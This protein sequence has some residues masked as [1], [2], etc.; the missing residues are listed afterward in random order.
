M[1]WKSAGEAW[2]FRAAEWAY[3]FE[4]Y[5][6][7]ANVAVLDQCGVTAGTS[8]LDIGCGSGYALR[9]AADRGASVSG[10]DASESLLRIAAART[11]YAD[12]RLGD[13]DA[14]PWDDN[15]VRRGDP[16]STR[17][18]PTARPRPQK[19]P[20]SSSPAGGSE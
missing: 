19:P 8:V 16:A 17:S 2:G 6:R 12:L 20:A 13:M 4:P 9:L 14:L 10:L 1:G 5:S 11:P 3:L 18:G 15:R 7:T